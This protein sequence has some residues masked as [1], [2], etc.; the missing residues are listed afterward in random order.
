MKMPRLGDVVKRATQHF[1]AE[2]QEATSQTPVG[3]DGAEEELSRD[4]LVEAFSQAIAFMERE[5]ALLSDDA[6]A[7][8]MALLPEKTASINRL[9]Q[10]IE[11]VKE[12]GQLPEGAAEPLR[13]LQQHFDDVAERNQ[14]LLRHALETQNTVMRILIESALE[15]SQHGYGQTGEAGRDSSR[16]SFS[17]DNKV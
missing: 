10:L 15:E 2:H 4:A 12:N 16:S 17:L 9:G 8:A 5:N 1:A 11:A 14:A 7:E 13:E 3:A 6:M